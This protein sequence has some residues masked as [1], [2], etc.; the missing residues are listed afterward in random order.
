[1]AEES[2][3]FR[4]SNLE[5]RIEQ[6]ERK[7][8]AQMARIAEIEKIDAVQ[9]HD[10]ANIKAN[11]KETLDLVR[12]IKTAIDERRGGA[13]WS[14]WGIGVVASAVGIFVG[15]DKLTGE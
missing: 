6:V 13:K 2:D 12:E 14:K 1:M 4:I 3:A 9:S 15:Y 7:A 11:G 10:I 8:E 5:R